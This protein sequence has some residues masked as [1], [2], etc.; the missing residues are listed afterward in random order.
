MRIASTSGIEPE[1]SH[2]CEMWQSLPRAHN[3]PMYFTL[4][5]RVL[6]HFR[7]FLDVPHSL[8]A[9]NAIFAVLDDKYPKLCIMANAYLLPFRQ[10][11]SL[12]R[13]TPFPVWQLTFGRWTVGDYGYNIGNTLFSSSV[14]SAFS[15]LCILFRAQLG[16]LMALFLHFPFQCSILPI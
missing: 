16:A 3:P 5:A 6:I 8:L 14:R 9:K 11:V 4:H 1:I 2:C 10:D 13:P 15:A 7:N 12:A